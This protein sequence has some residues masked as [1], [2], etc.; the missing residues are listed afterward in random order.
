MRDVE[1]DRETFRTNRYRIA[2]TGD[3]R[4]M[5]MREGYAAWQ[6]SSFGLFKHIS[7]MVLANHA[8]HSVITKLSTKVDI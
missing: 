4:A 8:L 6:E 2:Y 7:V 1:V 5:K 3:D